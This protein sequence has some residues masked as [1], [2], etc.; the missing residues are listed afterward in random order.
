M[1]EYFRLAFFLSEILACWRPAPGY[2]FHSAHE[3]HVLRLSKT[4]SLADLFPAHALTCPATP[5]LWRTSGE[6]KIVLAAVPTSEVVPFRGE[7]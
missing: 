5:L 3:F 2:P 1:R 6:N 7:L 4:G